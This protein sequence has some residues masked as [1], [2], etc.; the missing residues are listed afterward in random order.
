MRI[1]LFGG[2]FDPVHSAHL[3]LAAAALRELKLS[4]VYFVL[5]PKSPFKQHKRQT[6]V[7]DRLTFLRRALDGNEKFHIARWELERPGPSYTVDT[8]LSYKKRFPA[9]EL[10]FIMGSDGLEKFKKWKRPAMI[11][12]NAQLVVGRRPGS[13]DHLPKKICGQKILY[14]KTAFPRLSSTEI[15]ERLSHAGR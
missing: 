6:P 5:S 10:F 9:H 7:R 1:G 2:S 4:R 15:R 8:I 3:K 12:K 11:V 14:L 13:M